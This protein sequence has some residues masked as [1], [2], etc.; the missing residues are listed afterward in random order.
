MGDDM[1]PSDCIN[2]VRE[3]GGHS[4]A[5]M[6]NGRECWAGGYMS[7]RYKKSDD[8]CNVPCKYDDKTMCGGDGFMSIWRA[9][10]PD[11]LEKSRTAE[12]YN[13]MV[14]SDGRCNHVNCPATD[15]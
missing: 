6:V 8:K 4:R 12:C 14:R 7:S 13:H 10:R 3:E 9:D 2:A 15:S 5:A 1:S 11:N